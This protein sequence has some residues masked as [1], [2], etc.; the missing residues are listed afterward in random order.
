MRISMQTAPGLVLALGAASFGGCTHSRVANGAL[1]GAGAGA[2]VAGVA[3][4]SML[5]GAAVGAV[6]GAV[7]GAITRHD[8]GRCY[9]RDDHGNDY[10]VP[11]R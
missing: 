6:G 4:G 7:V 1:I 9:R 10:Q 3:G 11:C 8:D 5:G 2:A